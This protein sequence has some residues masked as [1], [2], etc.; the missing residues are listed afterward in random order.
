M[1][2]HETIFLGDKA[3]PNPL[4]AWIRSC[5]ASG[6]ASWLFSAVQN[7]AYSKVSADDYSE[8]FRIKFGLSIVESDEQAP[9]VWYCESTH[10]DDFDQQ[11]H[12]RG[13]KATSGDGM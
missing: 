12:G 3:L 9:A 13:C 10:L 2:Q 5:V 7:S 4:N 11:H 8:N 1:I 6:C